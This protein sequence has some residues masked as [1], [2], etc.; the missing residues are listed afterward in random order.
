MKVVYAFFSMITT[1]GGERE[2]ERRSR[3]P[4]N[5]GSFVTLRAQA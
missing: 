2:R 5:T 3:E 4:R 1:I